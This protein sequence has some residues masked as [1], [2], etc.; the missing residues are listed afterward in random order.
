MFEKIYWCMLSHYGIKNIFEWIIYAYNMQLDR[1][2]ND[3]TETDISIK[4]Q[5]ICLHDDGSVN[6]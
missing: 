5:L 6:D 1:S 2:H 4:I 3:L